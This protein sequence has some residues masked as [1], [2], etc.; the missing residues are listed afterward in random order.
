MNASSSIRLSRREREVAGLVAEGLT[1][2]E[3][4]RRLFISERTAEGH[5]QQI[6]NKLGFDNR[7]QIAAWVAG[8]ALASAA[9]AGASQPAA[10][11]ARHNLPGQLT[12][13]IGRER[14]LA[15]VR[16][17]LQKSR[18][19]TIVG[20]AGCGKTRL[21]VQAAAEGLHRFPDG[22]WFVELSAITDPLQLPQAMAVALEVR[23]RHDADLVEAIAA[24]LS[25]SRCRLQCLVILDNCEHLIDQCASVA[26]RLLEAC[27]QMRV[28]ATSREPLQVNGEA[29]CKLEP[30]SLPERDAGTSADAIRRFEAIQLFVDRAG[31]SDPDFELADA[32]AAT[33]AEICHRL[34]GIPLALELAAARVGLMPLDAL[35]ERLRDRFTLLRRRAAPTRQQTLRAAIGWSYE[36][37]SEPER[38]LF[39]RLSVFSGGCSPEAVQAVCTLDAAAGDLP[40]TLEALVVKSLLVRVPGKGERYRML[41]TVRQYALEKLTQS[42]ELEAVRRRHLQF[43]VALADRGSIEMNGPRQPAWVERLAEEHDNLRTALEQHRGQDVEERLRLVLA[44]ERYLRLRGHL[45]EGRAW[46]E[47]ALAVPG[48]PTPARASALNVAAM[49]AWL[50]GDLPR[51][52]ERL[53]ASLAIRRELGDEAGIQTCLANLGVIASTRGDW[54]AAAAWAGESLVLAERLGNELATGILLGNLGLAAAYLGDHD[55]ALT[56]LTEGLAIIRRLGDTARVANALA[57]LGMLALFR[58]QVGEARDRYAESLRILEGLGEPQG[59]AECLEGFAAIEAGRSDWGRALRLAGA[60]AGLRESSGAPQRPWS[61]RV[62]DEWLDRARAALGEAAEPAWSAG[63]SMTVG[64]AVAL[65]LE[66]H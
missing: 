2:R 56:R 38:R 40:A 18:L 66:E 64:Q 50:Q 53:Q 1:D 16:R 24:E 34:D 27:P 19:V 45:S 31:L 9:P 26:V 6:R 63:R 49:M 59:L 41:E 58:G 29:I 37:L 21:A 4:A 17:Q 23:E 28:L 51:A 65:A 10:R 20:P 11:S 39:R 47:S 57:N 62:V 44:L 30:M 32:N 42:G 54:E 3:I 55:L 22:A 48:A 5:V 7:S 36:L 60:A 35:L 33:V 43:F 8:Q 52:Q 12:S 15:S 25:T 13:F 46:V 14:E 61:R